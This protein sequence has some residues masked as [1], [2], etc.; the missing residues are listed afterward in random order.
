MSPS[1]EQ[2]ALARVRSLARSLDT[3]IALPGG[4]RIGWEAVLGLIPGVGDAAGAVLSTYIVLQAVR[5]GASRE[6]LVR[7][8]GN[9]AL[10]A[11][12]GAVPFLGDVFDAAFKANVR[13]V[14]LLEAHLAAPDTT[15]RAS[16]AWVVGV[17]VVLLT[18]LSLAVVLAVLAVRALLSVG[19]QGTLPS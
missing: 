14:R 17:V 5:L 15:T 19:G 8:V 1:S 10:E 2:D 7:M 6:V 18:L 4:F 3:S 11:L 12:V 13:N 9:V 16:R